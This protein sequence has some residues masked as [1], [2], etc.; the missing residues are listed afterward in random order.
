MISLVP[1]YGQ[2]VAP[3]DPNALVQKIQGELNGP[4]L[5]ESSNNPAVPQGEFLRGVVNSKIYP[6]TANEFQVWVPAQYDPAKPAC[7]LLVLDG[8]GGQEAVVN[9]LMAEK[10]MPVAIVIGISPGM[11]FENQPGKLQ[12]PM[13][14]IRSFEFDGTNDY[15]PNY[16]LNELLPAVEQV[17]TQNG[18][19]IHLSRDGNDHAVMGASSG[20]IGAFTLAWQRPDQFRR[21]FS[22]IGTFVPMRGGNEYAPLVRKTESKPIR[23]FLEDGSIDAWSTDFGMWYDANL[24]LESALTFAG[25]DVAHAWGTHGHDSGPG[26]TILPDVLRWLWRDY[27]APIVAGVSQNYRLSQVV[28]PNEGWQKIGQTFQ[29]ATGL[30]A[31]PNGDVYLSD[32]PAKT[33]YRI[34]GDGKPASFLANEP[35]ITGA[36]F[37]PDGTLYGC[38]PGEKKIVAID[39]KGAVRT[40]THGIAGHGVTVTHDGTIYVSEPGEHAELPSTIWKVKPTGEKTALDHGLFPATGVAFQPDGALFYAAESSSRWVYSYVVQPDGS[41]ADRQPFYWLHA[42]DTP[43]N[44]GAEDLANDK[45]G[46]LYVATRMGIQLCDLRGEVGAIIPLPTPCGPVRS[47][48]F[49]GPNFDELYA[50]DGTQVFKRKMKAQGF[51]PWMAPVPMPAPGGP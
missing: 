18:R 4:R 40:V 22:M 20:G 15:F 13:R 41:F 26:T 8:I 42:A 5:P 44:A 14:Y 46:N 24:A 47:L 37:G 10:A 29:N 36:C 49:G 21:V 43:S 1:V 16:V 48:C 30:T 6:G 45:A 32:A 11:A 25:Y 51:A 50:T 33:I 17:K 12:R 34:G 19:A 27:P 23:I 38:V 28:A 7:F 2:Q 31:A 3:V 39:P 9:N 35:A